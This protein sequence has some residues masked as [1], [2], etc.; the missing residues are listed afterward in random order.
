MFDE[1]FMNNVFIG[2][3]QKLEGDIYQLRRNIKEYIDAMKEN[4]RLF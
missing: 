2:D 4:I 3:V 1:Y